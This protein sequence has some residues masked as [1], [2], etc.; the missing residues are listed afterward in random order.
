MKLYKPQ[1]YLTSTNGGTYTFREHSEEPDHKMLS[2]PTS[3]TSKRLTALSR[4][5]QASGILRSPISWKNR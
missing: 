2:S 4:D 5:G 3:M 1:V